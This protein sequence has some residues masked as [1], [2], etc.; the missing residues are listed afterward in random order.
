[1]IRRFFLSQKTS[2]EPNY[3][4]LK[5]R[6]TIFQNEQVL[7]SAGIENAQQNCVASIFVNF[8]I[9]P[10]G[11]GSPPQKKRKTTTINCSEASQ[12]G[13]GDLALHCGQ[14]AHFTYPMIDRSIIKYEIIQKCCLNILGKPGEKAL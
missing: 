8:I 1:M 12:R 7:F 9:S 2:R 14:S 3:S 5:G 13:G 4:D 10:Q 6:V 11:P